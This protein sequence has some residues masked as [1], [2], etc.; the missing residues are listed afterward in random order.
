MDYFPD[1]LWDL[2]TAGGQGLGGFGE[3]PLDFFFVQQWD[4]LKGVENGGR[5]E[6]FLRGN[7][8][9]EEGVVDLNGGC[10]IGYGGK[11]IR[12]LSNSQLFG[13]PDRLRF[14]RYHVLFPVRG[15][16]LLNSVEVFILVILC[17]VQLGVGGELSAPRRCG[18]KGMAQ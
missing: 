10:G 11:A 9:Y 14:Y 4:M 2:T 16:G 5:W 6:G 3:S 7:E 17:I 12:G 15:L 13:C 1:A 18:M 8:M